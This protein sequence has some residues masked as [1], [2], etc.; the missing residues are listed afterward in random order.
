MIPCSKRTVTA[1]V[2]AVDGRRFSST[3]Y[4]LAA[5]PVCPRADMPT[6]VGYELCRDICRQPAHA[7]V[8]ALDLAGAAALGG[9]MYVEGHSYACASCMQLA[10]ALGIAAVHFRAPPP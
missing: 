9:E 2:I 4:T 10:Q 1:T 6:G 7:E 3:N 8:N 5:P